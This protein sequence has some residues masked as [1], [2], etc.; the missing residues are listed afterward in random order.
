[1]SLKRVDADKTIFDFENISG[2]HYSLQFPSGEPDDAI[3]LRVL[4]LSSMASDINVAG[5]GY[6][7]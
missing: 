1:M 5:C 7:V 6:L 2:L 4:F 3:P